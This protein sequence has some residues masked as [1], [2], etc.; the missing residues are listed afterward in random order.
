MLTHDQRSWQPQGICAVL[1]GLEL[2]ADWGPWRLYLPTL[3][4][5]LLGEMEQ[6]DAGETFAY[7]R[8]EV[9][10]EQCLNSAQVLD[11]I[12]QITKKGWADDATV[13]G[14]ARAINDVLD[15]QA[16]LCSSGASSN[17]TKTQVAQLA[18]AA[19]HRWADLVHVRCDDDS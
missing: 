10:L 2:A 15:P 13:A 16:H 6:H 8:Y 11:W 14:L 7:E 18:K 5:V 9:D 4:L 3:V 1:E 19:A 17:I 12:M